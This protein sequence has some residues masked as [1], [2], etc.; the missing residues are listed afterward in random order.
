MAPSVSPQTDGW[1][2]GPAVRGGGGEGGGALNDIDR[3]CAAERV[4]VPGTAG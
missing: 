2:G 4:A 3:R 1:G